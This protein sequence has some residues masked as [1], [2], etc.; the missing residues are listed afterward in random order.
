[1]VVNRLESFRADTDQFRCRRLSI[2]VTASD[3][4]R[5]VMSFQAYLDTI[6]IKTGHTPRELVEQAA[7]RGSARHQGRA[8]S[9]MAE[10]RVRA[11]PWTRHGAGPR[12]HQGA[13]DQRETRRDVRPAPRCQRHAVARRGGDEPVTLTRAGGGGHRSSLTICENCLIV[14][15]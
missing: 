1:M 2:L 14:G 5:T 9:R 3:D 6:E 15:T 10:G 12:H 7:E 8:D 4:R 11:R 13:E